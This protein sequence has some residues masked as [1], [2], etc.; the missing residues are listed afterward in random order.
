MSASA[1]PADRPLPGVLHVD[2]AYD[3]GDEI[4]LTQAAKLAPSEEQG[5]LRRP[6]TPAS[7]GYHPVPLRF[8]LTAPALE[9]PG[10]DSLPAT[11]EATVFDFGGVTIRADLTLTLTPDGWRRLADDQATLGEWVQ[12]IRAAAAPLFER[13]QPAIRDAEWGDVS[14]EFFVFHFQPADL[15]PI[16]RLLSESAGWLAGLVRLESDALCDDE[17]TEA[18]R[19]RLRYSPHDL[20]I[21]DWA[22]AIVVD[23]ECDETLRT[24]EFANLQLLEFR[25]LER[26][27]GDSLDKAYALIHRAIRS[28]SLLGGASNKSLRTLGDLRMETEAMFERAG[29]AFQ[30]VGDQYLARLY[31]QLSERF[32]LSEWSGSIRQTL[33]VVEGVYRVLADQAAAHRIEIMELVVIIL[34]AV[35]I[36]LSLIHG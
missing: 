7:I 27:L 18:L 3:W 15:P 35:E 17:T 32:H 14:E 29:N 30:L 2:V 34:I 20:V 12:R 25:H 8:P 28:P 11:L 16:D 26:R 21:V 9:L 6:R 4:D 13:L 22:A 1:L 19:Q 10:G 33:D 31:R 5:L 23:S 24:M 36:V